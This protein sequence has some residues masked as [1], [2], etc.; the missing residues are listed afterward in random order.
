MKNSMVKLKSR[1]Y[2]IG[3]LPL[4]TL[5]LLTLIVL[6]V[7]LNMFPE[8]VSQLLSDYSETARSISY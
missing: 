7:C 8:T 2:L 6:S 4:L 1:G 5:L 3:Y